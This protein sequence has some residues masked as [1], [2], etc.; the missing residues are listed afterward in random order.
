MN[1][2]IVTQCYNGVQ[3]DVAVFLTDEQALTQ[4]GEWAEET[5]LTKAQFEVWQ[6]E[7]MKDKNELRWFEQPFSFVEA[8]RGVSDELTAE[9]AGEVLFGET[10]DR[11]VLR[12]ATLLLAGLVVGGKVPYKTIGHLLHYIAD[13][14]E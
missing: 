11:P 5:F 9:P 10:E 7:E 8:L 13:M 4:L 1:L 14:A 12:A 3:E 2:Q 6:A